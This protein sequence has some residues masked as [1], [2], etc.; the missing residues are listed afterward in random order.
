MKQAIYVDMDDVITETTRQYLDVARRMFGRTVLYEDIRN[1]DLKASFGLTDDQFAAFFSEI[2][3]RHFLENLPPVPHALPSLARWRE[4]GFAI[5]VVTGRLTAAYTASVNWLRHRGVPM[6][7]F[8]MVDKYARPDMN[9]EI[10][11]PLKSFDTEPFAFAV[12]DSPATALFLAA[13][14]KIPV[15]LMDRPW[16]QGIRHPGIQRIFSWQDIPD[17]GCSCP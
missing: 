1:F 6:D 13:E 11:I 10:S 8:V 5:H 17:S 3:E 4:K 16:N 12:E 9:P 14:R 7:A 15:F 2:H